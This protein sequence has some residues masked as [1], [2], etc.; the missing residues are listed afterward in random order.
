[1]LLL[2]CIILDQRVKPALN[3][4]PR[5]ILKN[6]VKGGDSIGFA[7]SH[8]VEDY[9]TT[10]SAAATPQEDSQ[11]GETTVESPCATQQPAGLRLLSW[12][13][14]VYDGQLGCQPALSTVGAGGDV[15]HIQDCTD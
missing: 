15:I 14:H 12:G 1:M 5:C 8:L 3:G 2:E 10:S 6:L 13:A 7:R 9:V 4:P 11:S